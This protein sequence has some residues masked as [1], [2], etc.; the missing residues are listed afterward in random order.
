MFDLLIVGEINPD[1]VLWGSDVLPA[2]GQAEKL[3]EECTLTIGSS[4]VITACGAAKLGLSVAFIGLT[5]D[6]YFGRFMLESMGEWGIDI[7][8]CIVDPAVATG[9]S[10]I[11]AGPD[12]RA[13]L[14]Y[15]G[16][17]PCLRIE[18]VDQSLLRKA[19]H[20]HVGSYFLLDD[21]RPDL[22]RLFAMA[23]ELGL[24]TSLDSNWDP[25]GIWDVSAVLPHIDI[26]S[27]NG[28]EVRL[29]TGQDE[30]S[31]GM[32]VLARQVPV[33]AVKLGAQGGLVRQGEQVMEAPAL[34]VTVVDTIGA[35]DSFNAGFL[36]GYLNEYELQDAIELACVCGSLSTRAAGGT[37]AQP[38]LQEAQAALEQYKDHLL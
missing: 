22:P 31:A 5:G 28:N 13:I 19:R 32:D 24:S 3:V 37:A 14:T 10:V 34:P 33:L 30:F 36:F 12:D 26:F 23:K 35:G 21:L 27:P 29:I 9:L 8:A 17:M 38:D 11:L 1:L 25:S 6:D 4:S 2:F 16:A 15:P 7:S 18:Q 20:L